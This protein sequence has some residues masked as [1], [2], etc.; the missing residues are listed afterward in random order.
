MSEY[1]AYPLQWPEGVARREV[2]DMMPARFGSKR[3]SRWID[4]VTTRE[5]IDRLMQEISAMTPAGRTWRIDP[6]QVVISSN[7]RTRA[8]GQ[9]YSN[10]RDP[11]DPAVCVYFHLDGDP[12]A[13]PCDKW[14]RVADN[15]CAI[16]KHIGAMRGMERWGVGD[17]R[18]AFAGFKALPSGGTAGGHQ[19][20]LW[21]QVLDVD[22]DADTATVKRAYRVAAAKAHPDR[23]GSSA[24]F[25]AVQDAWQAFERSRK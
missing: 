2:H 5:A 12:H 13:M 15:I 19:V 9:P 20:R 17:L 11:D 25:Q 7:V 8:D 22:Q 14:D 10:A 24:E 23:G 21:W 16:A 6:A 18:T 3:N 4:R 1:Q